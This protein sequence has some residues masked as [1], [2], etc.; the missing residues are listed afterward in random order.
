[1]EF[2]TCVNV[3]KELFYSA[4]LFILLACT[5]TSAVQDKNSQCHNYAGGHVYPG[6]AFRVP[7]S[8]HSLHLSKA[9]SEF[10]F[11]W[12]AMKVLAYWWKTRKFAFRFVLFCSSGLVRFISGQ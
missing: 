2:F 3:K 5:I 9:K 4:A 11:H 1:M 8:D 7:V 12:L 6:E 10:L